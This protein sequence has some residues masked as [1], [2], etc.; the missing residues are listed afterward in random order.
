MGAAEVRLVF[1]T[2]LHIYSRSDIL[3]PTLLVQVPSSD[4]VAAGH[5]RHVKLAFF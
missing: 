5:E 4:A 2:T 3:E 1:S